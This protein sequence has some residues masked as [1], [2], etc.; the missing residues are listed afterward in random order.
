MKRAFCLLL[1]GSIASAQPAALSF[2]SPIRL[3]TGT[4]PQSVLIADVNHDGI[5]D[6]LVA[7]NGSSNLTV[8]LGQGA[9]E[10]KMAPGSP[11]GAGPSPN[12]LTPG[13]FNGD[14]HFDLAIAN[15][16]VKLVTLLLGDGT[17]RFAFA[18]GS[19]FAV[20]SN[21]HP[22]GIAAADFDEDGKLDLAV[23]SWGENKVLVLFGN[24]D[25]TF[26]TNGVKFDVGA[27]PY[28]RLRTANLDGDGHADIITSNWKG[29]SVS[30]LRGDGKGRFALAGGANIP[31]PTSP[32]G[33]AIGDFNGDRQPDIAIVHYSGQATDRSR[34]G[35]S[36][37]LG[38]G[39]GRFALARGSPF[40]VGHYPPTV[41]AGDLNR[42]GITDIA[43]PN[44]L[45]NSVTIYL[46]GTNGI[47]PAAGSPIKVGR[48]PAGVAIGDLDGDGKPDLVVTEAEDN[49]VLVLFSK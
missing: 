24:G 1:A 29:D 49:D 34:N 48:G 7:N 8:Y 12:D 15:H 13:D 10:F 23:D 30:V 40:P 44:Y 28:E 33:I 36:V 45:D 47:H 21:P 27:A 2:R 14:G 32:F 3:R 31:V 9:G 41:A 20:A 18:P 39:K 35:L 42:D 38:D 22:H 46:G 43:V 25:G 6:L 17:G 16:G 26:R 37:L 4:Y 11:F 5:A 19:P